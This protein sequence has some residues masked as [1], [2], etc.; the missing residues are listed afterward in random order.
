MGDQEIPFVERRAAELAT[1]LGDAV[2]AKREK[3]NMTQT[4]FATVTGVSRSFINELERGRNPRAQLG[5][6]L[7]VAQAARVDLNQVLGMSAAAA[8]NLPDIPESDEDI[9]ASEEDLDDK[10]SPGVL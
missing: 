8:A 6:A 10:P 4:A 9:P 7:L 3:M 2:R 5:L 1:R